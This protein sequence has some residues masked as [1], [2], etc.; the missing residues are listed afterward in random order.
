MR[1]NLVCSQFGCLRE[2]LNLPLDKL[3]NNDRLEDEL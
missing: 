1:L 3:I 2:E